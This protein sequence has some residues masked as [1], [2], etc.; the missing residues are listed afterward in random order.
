MFIKGKVNFSCFRVYA[1]VFVGPHYL[2][3]FARFAGLFRWHLIR[4][5]CMQEQQKMQFFVFRML[6]DVR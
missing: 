6:E 5:I 1:E 3:D 2:L 4:T